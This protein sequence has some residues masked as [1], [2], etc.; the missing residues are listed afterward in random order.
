MPDRRKP[1]SGLSFPERLRRMRASGLATDQFKGAMSTPDRTHSDLSA[2]VRLIIEFLST[3]R[4]NTNPGM[5]FFVMY[6]IEDNKIRGHVSKYLI[7]NG[8]LRMQKSVFIGNVPHK[9]YREIADTL[10]EVNAMYSNGDSI[11]VLPVTRETIAQL[12]VIGKD[13]NYKMATEPPNVL[14]I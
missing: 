2:R 6:D 7:R 5:L 11:L 9:K 8:C 12:Q 14:I 1:D 10:E 3:K 4:D 13:L